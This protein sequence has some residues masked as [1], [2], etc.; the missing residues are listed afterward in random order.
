MKILNAF[1][2]GYFKQKT[3]ETGRSMVE[4]LGVLA[5]IGVLSIGGIYGYT[6][7]MDKYRA[8]D[9]VYEVNL[10][11]TDVWH[12]Y[13]EQPLPDPSEDGTDFDE[14]PDMTG[15]GYPIYMTSHPDVAFKTYV[16]G[17]SSRVCKNVVNMNL[18]GIVKGI[19]FVQVA[20]GE[21]DLVKYTGNASICGEDETDNLIVFT[22]FLDSENNEAGTGQ[23]GDPCVEDMD[24]SSPCGNATCDTDKM[25]CKNSCT[26][27]NKPI[28]YDNGETGT[29][30]EC[31][32]N[33]DCSSHG[34]NYVCN[35]SDHTCQEMR[36]CNEGK[37]YDSSKPREYRAKN[38]ACIPCVDINAIEISSDKFIDTRLNI[39]DETT[40]TEQCNACANTHTVTV[41][42]S[43]GTTYCAVAC[44]KGVTYES[45]SDGCIPCRKPDGTPNDTAYQIPLTDKARKLC[46]ACGL[47]WW[48]NYYQQNSCDYFPNC[49]KGTFLVVGGN[50]T[51]Y[52]CTDNVQYRVSG[53][54]GGGY[55]EYKGSSGWSSSK[56]NA[57]CTENCKDDNGNPIRELG[58]NALCRPICEQ[59]DEDASITA[60]TDGDDSTPCERQYRS[61]GQCY[62][63]SDTSSR[64]I[65]TGG[66]DEIDT[67]EEKM[68][69]ACGRTARNGYC[70]IEK[71]LKTGQ[72][73]GKD[74][75]PYNCDVNG[76]D[77]VSEE[78]SGCI[79]NCRKKN[80]E[81]STDADAVATRWIYTDSNGNQ[82]CLKICP[83]NQWQNTGG[84]CM[85][86]SQDNGKY[87]TYYNTYVD[88]DHCEKVCQNTAYPREK[89]SYGD[90]LCVLKTCPND[91][92]GMVRYRGTMGD[93]MR[94]DRVGDS[95]YGIAPNSLIMAEQCRRCNNRITSVIMDNISRCILIDPGVSGVCN[96]KNLTFPTNMDS[97]LKDAIQPYLDGDYDGFKFRDDSGNCHECTTEKAVST[98]QVQCA[99]CNTKVMQRTY[100]GGVCSLG[101]CQTNEFMNNTPD[102]VKCTP[103]SEPSSYINATYRLK[104]EHT[105]TC[106]QC[107]N[108]QVLTV[109]SNGLQYCVPTCTTGSGWQ[110]TQNGKCLVC[111]EDNNVREIGTEAVYRQQCEACNRVAFSQQTSDKTI[112]YCS[113]Q[114]KDGYFIDSTGQL[115]SCT[116][117]VDIMITDTTKAKAVCEASGCNRMIETD[118]DGN[119]WCVRG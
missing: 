11:A 78:D 45:L 61:G 39:E 81:Y 14:F 83:E 30:V 105:A 90:G 72:F 46:E 56:I 33:Q 73:R 89:V 59:P 21:G 50:P 116:T 3:A 62:A 70:M 94:C 75:E 1:L 93:C 97:D 54:E 53:W 96:S 18:N 113:K 24:C 67:Y 29:C 31:M 80:G 112:W 85:P 35:T 98:S 87:S 6:F 111:S 40:G 2:N 119:V 48:E 25:T 60:C 102:C 74:G 66:T 34:E 19:Q 47:V 82:K 57:Q 28:C 104:S 17:V 43:T 52:P 101:G 92:D 117:D 9:I 20:Q 42:E 4:I 76:K 110:S 63:C 103:N 88:E 91:T 15:T 12:K 51:C 27:T 8:N 41:D 107:G 109:G 84:M 86:C 100:S 114:A 58:S 69:V 10:R 44:I 106:G 5:I 38:G 16:E 65:A 37:N 68:C 108:R 99:L 23:S 36:V 79:K 95:Q 22:S 32:V 71:A 64:S 49:E 77:I 55:R 13:Q 26:G 7:A 118:D 115:E